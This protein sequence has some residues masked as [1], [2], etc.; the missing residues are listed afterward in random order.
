MQALASIL[1]TIT[2][3][4]PVACLPVAQATAPE[5]L[6]YSC[7]ATGYRLPVLRPPLTAPGLQATAAGLQAA[8]PETLTYSCRAT[9]LQAA[10][11]ETPNHGYRAEWLSGSS[12]GAARSSEERYSFP[13]TPLSFSLLLPSSL[14]M[15]M[16]SVLPP[17]PRPLSS[18]LE[19]IWTM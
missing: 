8:A 9:G 6:T 13:E 11:P 5:T 2:L 18:V 16:Q 4:I 10:A 14:S 1:A 15:L 3:N 17:Q 7:R 19:E 12:F